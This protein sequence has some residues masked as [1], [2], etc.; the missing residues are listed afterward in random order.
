MKVRITFNDTKFKK[1][2]KDFINKFIK[3]LQTQYPL[4]E[5]VKIMFL[6]KQMGGMSTGSRNDNSELKVLAKNRLNRDIMRTL[7]HE[8]VHEHQR[9]VLKRPHGPNIGGKNED[10]ANAFAGRLVKMFEKKYPDLESMM[11]ESKSIENKLNLLT[12]QILLTEKESI[13]ENLISEMKK[14]GIEELPYSYSSLQKFI[15]SKTMNIHYNKHYKGYVDKLNKALKDKDGDMELEEI[16]KSISKFDTKVR[17]NAGGAFNHALFWKMLSPKKQVPKGEIYKQIKKDFGNIKKMKD[18][19][20]EAAKDRFGSGWAWLYLTKDGKLKIMSLPNQDNPLMNV[21]KKGGFPLLGLDVWEH[22]YYLKY[23]NKRD[24]YISNFWNVVNWEFVNDLYMTKTKKEKKPLKENFNPS[25]SLISR[26]CEKNRYKVFCLYKELEDTLDETSKT[27]LND[28]VKSIWSKFRLNKNIP[29][30]ILDLAI[31]D[32]N[33]TLSNLE[34]VNNFIQSEYYTKQRKN[35]FLRKLYDV[36]SFP[37][38]KAELLLLSAKDDP[39]RF[40]YGFVGDVFESSPT[41]LRLDYKCQADSKERLWEIL[42]TISDTGTTEESIT[43]IF[44]TITE[45]LF[46][47]MKGKNR[48]KRDLITTAPLKYQGVEVFPSRSNFE[49]KRFDSAKDSYLSEFFSIFKEGTISREK[50]HLNKIYNRMVDLIYNILD[51]NDGGYTEDILS[52]LAGLIIKGP[53]KQSDVNTK[54]QDNVIIPK[55]YVDIY[56]SNQGQPSCSIEK[57]LSLRYRVKGSPSEAIA[58]RYNGTD[59][60]EEL[61]LEEKQKIWPQNSEKIVCPT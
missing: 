55:E 61:T 37:K 26:E 53:I 38:N 48:I 8:W 45:C 13:K 19:F 9:N 33:T 18:E 58:Y 39:T 29:L 30:R 3:F 31:K 54:M 42:D 59:E 12:E 35:T 24:E 22:A 27:K 23:Q 7:A 52:N 25:V 21:V 2:D 15:D 34:W 14:I 57:R 40:E 17:N 36:E 4:K 1:D 56:W 11:Y 20:N 60:L 46:Q 50:R 16:I 5:D 28:I 47:S 49:V 41:S 43:N 51:K 44:N 32:T 10:E 6:G